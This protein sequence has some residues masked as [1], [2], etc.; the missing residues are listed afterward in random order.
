MTSVGERYFVR[1][2][3][4][5][6]AR[7]MLAFY[8]LVLLASGVVQVAASAS[9]SPTLLVGAIVDRAADPSAT[10]VS[11]PSGASSASVS[12]TKMPERSETGGI[13]TRV[14]FSDV[15]GTLVHYPKESHTQ[16]ASA[17]HGDDDDDQGILR[18]PPSA[19]GTR[20]IISCRTL[21]LC[22]E[23]RR[24]QQQRDESVRLVLVSGMRT[25]TLL[26]RLPYLPKADAYCSEGG[27]RIFYPVTSSP[28]AEGTRPKH[29]V[30]PVPFEGATAEDLQPFYV[31]EDE[32]WRQR[33][34]AAVG[35]DGFQSNE[36]GTAI[37]N[38]DDNN[39]DN[40]TPVRN[41]KGPLW[42][43]ANHLAGV[44]FV[45]D[46]KGY[47]ACFRIN[48]KHQPPTVDFDSLL[49]RDDPGAFSVPPELA[50]ST[51]LGCVD[52]YPAMSGKKNWYGY[53]LIA[54]ASLPAFVS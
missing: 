16:G 45:V 51:N 6:G 20:G 30:A 9:S 35:D 8:L 11:K 1:Y 26:Q 23:I 10:D 52:V 29:R 36:I 43:F 50:T 46:T 5:I 40:G 38:G 22:R 2:T 13:I 17:V 33:I 21:R 3:G 28:R 39:N 37:D 15:D 41:R 4:T 25:S 34:V 31:E 42:D 47:A 53:N 49:R 48:R 27:S 54:I 14:V 18:L 32:L 12:A 19:T 7:A 44:G 24:Q